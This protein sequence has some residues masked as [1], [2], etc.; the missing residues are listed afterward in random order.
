[1]LLQILT[2]VMS[3]IFVALYAAKALAREKCTCRDQRGDYANME[4]SA[5]K[6][7]VILDEVVLERLHR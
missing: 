7:V 1:M 6:I 2:K 5:H 3:A 4:A